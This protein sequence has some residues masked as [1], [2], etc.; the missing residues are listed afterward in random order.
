MWLGP[1]TLNA[2][3]PCTISPGTIYVDTSKNPDGTNYA[4]TSKAVISFVFTDD[5]NWAPSPGIGTSVRVNN[6]TPVPTV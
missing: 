2:V 6:I 3:Y 1:G 5:R 4:G